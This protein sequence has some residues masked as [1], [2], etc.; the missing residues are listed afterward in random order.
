MSFLKNAFSSKKVKPRQQVSRS[1]LKLPA[2][3]LYRDLSSK[4][5]VIDVKLA[6]KKIVFDIKN[7][8][9]NTADVESLGEIIS[10]SSTQKIRKQI[11]L[12]Q[13]ENNLLKLK[14]EVLLNLVTES[15]AGKS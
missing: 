6:D 11:D 13:E 12:L 7:D 1:S 4:C 9:W 2:D 14:V 5:E 3:E 15:I 10:S 8:D